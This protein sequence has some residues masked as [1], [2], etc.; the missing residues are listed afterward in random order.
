MNEHALQ[1]VSGQAI[2]NRNAEESRSVTATPRVDIWETEDELMVQLD[3]PGVKPADV[4]VRFEN[5]ELSVHGKRQASRTDKERLYWETELN[6][7]FR[8][9]QVTEEVASD[10][11]SAE[12]KQGV[13]TLRLPKVEAVKPRKI[14]VQG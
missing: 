12:L 14:T 1:A 9:F 8:S 7:Y 10:K 13:L 3:M 4:D 6:S 5:G 11:I 2:A